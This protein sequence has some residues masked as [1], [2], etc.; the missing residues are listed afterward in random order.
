MNSPIENL[1]PAQE[2]SLE[3]P[4]DLRPFL[5]HGEQTQESEAVTMRDIRPDLKQRIA[6]ARLKRQQAMAMVKEA[7]VE[8]A[9]LRKIR[10]LE[11]HRLE[12]PAPA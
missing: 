5:R 8:E 3:A 7:E 11:N 12:K 6:D 4:F 2:S 1:L 9:L 10:D